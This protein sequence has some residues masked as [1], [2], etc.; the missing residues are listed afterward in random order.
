MQT[1]FYYTT[2]IFTMSKFVKLAKTQA[3]LSK[4]VTA[5]GGDGSVGLGN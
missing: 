4:I 1:N 3:D 5:M 2:K